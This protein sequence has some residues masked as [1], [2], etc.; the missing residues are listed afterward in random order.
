MLSYSKE[1]GTDADYQQSYWGI[2]KNENSQKNVIGLHFNFSNIIKTFDQ[3]K[4]LS[5]ESYVL[6][7]TSGGQDVLL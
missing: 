6:A 5:K 7:K 4:N 3:E 2:L 1:R